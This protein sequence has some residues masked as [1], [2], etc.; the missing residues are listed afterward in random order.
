MTELLEIDELSINRINPYTATGTFGISYNGGHKSTEALPWM[1]PRE[2]PVVP[3]ETPEY[4]DHFTPK[5][6]FRA[7][8]M[9]AMTGGVN[10]ATSFMY[11]ARKYQ[12]DD[13]TTSWSREVTYTDGRNYISSDMF[14]DNLW[15]LIIAMGLLIIVLAL[16]KKLE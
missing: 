14:R 6:I 11:P 7:P 8:A 12:F 1:M 3:E 16:R 15:P 13:G 2:E 10:P 4:D 9:A 5:H